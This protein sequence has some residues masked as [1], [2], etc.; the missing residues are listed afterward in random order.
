MKI[1]NFFKEY[2]IFLSILLT[3]IFWFI[4]SYSSQG[5]IHSLLNL[6]QQTTENF[7]NSFGS[8]SIIIFVVLV[9][10]EVVVAIIPPGALYI[11][12]GSVYGPFFG[13]LLSLIGNIL[14]AFIA[15]KIARKYGRKVIEKKINKK[16]LRR[17][18]SFTYKHGS[19]SLFLLR[20]NPLTSSDL[21]SYIYG[22]T[23]IKTWKFLLFTSVGLIPLIFTQ[24]YFG[25]FINKNSIIFP[26]LILITLLFLLLIG[27]FVI[28]QLIIKTEKQIEKE[29]KHIKYNHKL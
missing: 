20:I 11:V 24:S 22:F 8:F 23:K 1:K 27:Y 15:F 10:L 4:Y 21:F 13:G 26:I 16:K 19:L 17:L 6:N 9:I 25:S 3:L 29:I 12:G 5:F 7:I 18:D 2:W 14:G 28:K